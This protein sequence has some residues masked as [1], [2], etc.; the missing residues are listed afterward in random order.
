MSSDDK[1]IEAHDCLLA[2]IIAPILILGTCK[3]S[4]TKFDHLGSDKV[5]TY[6][7]ILI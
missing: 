4:Y 5:L 7:N 6:G 2:F 3:V 1:Q